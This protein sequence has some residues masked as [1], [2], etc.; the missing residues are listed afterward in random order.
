MGKHE[1]AVT[2]DLEAREVAEILAVGPTTTK[3][4]HN[5]VDH[6]GRVALPRHGNV[7]DTLELG[8]RHRGKVPAPR[9]IV[10]ELAVR[11]AKDVQPVLVHDRRVPRASRRTARRWLHELPHGCVFERIEVKAPQLVEV[12]VVQLATKHH[13]VRA[14]HRQRVAV[15][16][17]RP[18]RALHTRRR[19]ARPF[20][21]VEI[22]QV[23]RVVLPVLGMDLGIATPQNKYVRYKYSCMAHAWEWCVARG[24]DE[25]G[26]Q[27]NVHLDA[28]RALDLHRFHTHNIHIVLHTVPHETTKDVHFLIRARRLVRRVAVP[29]E[30]RRTQYARRRAPRFIEEPGWV[31]GHILFAP[32]I[33]HIRLARALRCRRRG[34]RRRC[35]HR[36]RQRGTGRV[37]GRAWLFCRWTQHHAAAIRCAMRRRCRQA[38]RRLCGRRRG[39]RCGRRRRHGTWG[40][41]ARDVGRGHVFQRLMW[42]VAA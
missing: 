3:D 25:R 38:R 8:P 31:H 11:A 14:H 39:R 24:L 32:W 15:A 30:R 18:W 33:H 1:P 6:T 20:A 35:S 12:L 27:R 17:H 5:V 2:G 9:V 29:R 23:Q 37:D 40:R 36:H 22:Q 34:R 21:V 10:V 4:V 19:H 16:A 13:E 7:A 41:I 26:L 28:A 42:F